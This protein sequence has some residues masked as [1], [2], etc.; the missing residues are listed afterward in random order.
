MTLREAW[1]RFV[2]AEDY[3]THMAAI[4]RQVLPIARPHKADRPL[5]RVR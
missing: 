1:T 2:A 5:R 4:N 3:E